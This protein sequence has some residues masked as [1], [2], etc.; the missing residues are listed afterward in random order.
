VLLDV[1][2]RPVT[3]NGERLDL[4]RPF[5]RNDGAARQLD[6]MLAVWQGKIFGA[7]RNACWARPL[8]ARR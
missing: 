5:I 6:L 3:D 1:V 2:A 7:Q 8:M 4:A